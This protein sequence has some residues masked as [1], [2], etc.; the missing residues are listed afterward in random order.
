[1]KRIYVFILM[2]V[3]LGWSLDAQRLPG[4]D[5][6]PM[7]AA[8]YSPERGAPTV[9]KIYYSR[10]AK[11]DR[12]IFGALVPFGQ[13]WRT[14]ANETPEITFYRDVK[15]GGSD[16]KAGTYTLFTIP[17]ETEW[18]IILNSVLNQWGAYGYDNSKDVVRVKGTVS[19][20]PSHVEN[21]TMT[22]E[23]QDDGSAHLIM[24]WD[25]TLV[26]VPMM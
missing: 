3:G 18:T 7:D 13:V 6:S 1:M 9:A 26:R 14:G 25:N 22:W 10:P 15:F 24:A 16:V 12:E 2:M 8:A 23:K 4:L 17:G 21:F 11:K 5:A 19:T 20:P